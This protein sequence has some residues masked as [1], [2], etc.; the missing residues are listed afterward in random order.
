MFKFTRLAVLCLSAAAFC[1]CAAK[2]DYYED[3]AKYWDFNKLT[4]APAYR[5]SGLKQSKADG[6][7]D[8]LFDGVPVN[9]KTAPVFAYIAYPE[10]P[11]PKDCIFWN[12]VL[13]YLFGDRP[14]AFFSGRF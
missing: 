10:T 6:L 2:K 4:K 13:Y 8:I 3:P 14:L 5:P 7:Q 11:M 9:G 12:T 1:V